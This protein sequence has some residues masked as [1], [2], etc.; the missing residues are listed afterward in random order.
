MQ[1]TATNDILNSPFN[2]FN[3]ASLLQD[4]TQKGKLKRCIYGHITLL[5]TPVCMSPHR[6]W[7]WGWG[8]EEG[9]P[10]FKML[11]YISQLLL[12]PNNIRNTFSV[13]MY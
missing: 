1:V 5:S 11:T 7:E 3:M 12:S 4:D 9:K 13:S 6:I 10:L 8:L 2:I